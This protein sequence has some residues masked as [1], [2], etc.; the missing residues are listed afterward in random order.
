M[1]ASELLHVY[2]NL[3]YMHIRK[4]L[5]SGG[6]MQMQEFSRILYRYELM[7]GPVAPVILRVKVKLA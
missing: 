5:S 7:F 2:L 4:A 3:P 1:E 6:L